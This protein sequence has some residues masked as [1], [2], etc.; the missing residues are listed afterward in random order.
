MLQV[1]RNSVTVILAEYWWDQWDQWLSHFSPQLPSSR[2]EDLEGN[3]GTLR[4]AEW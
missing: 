3:S 4:E 1:P 2:S